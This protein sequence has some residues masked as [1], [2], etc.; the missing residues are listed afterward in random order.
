MELTPKVNILL[1]D[2]NPGKLL[3]LETILVGLDQ[4]IIKAHS[5]DEALTQLLRQ[6]FAVILLDVRMPDMDGLA[7]A[8]VIRSH[9]RTA[10]TPIIFISA[11]EYAAGQIFKGY[12]LGAVDYLHTLIPEV[13]RAKVAVFVKLAQTTAELRRLNTHLEQQV[14]ARTTQFQRAS[15]DL[16]QFARLSA[17]DFQEPLRQVITYAQLLQQRYGNKLDAGAEEFMGYLVAGAKRLQQLVLDL[18]AY[19][20]LGIHPLVT[21]MVEGEAVLAGA[22]SDLRG[23]IAEQGATITH[24]PLPSLRGEAAQLQL[25]FRNLLANAIKFRATL[26]P[27]VHIAATPQ[28]T[29]WVFTVAD[30]GIGIAPQ[31]HERIFRVFQRLHH[32]EPYPKPGIGLAICKKIIE[33]HGGRIWVE[34]APGQGATFFFTVPAR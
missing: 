16:Q 27:I 31:D 33:Q 29:E 12:A 24:D 1:V 25:V 15:E 22:L 23:L 10:Q 8:E 26:P 2:D 4:H 20:E 18:L 28:G 9:P 30:N 3:A 13:L 5:A 14:A 34:S 7:L 11:V 6:E 17:H 32:Q 19:T 21:T